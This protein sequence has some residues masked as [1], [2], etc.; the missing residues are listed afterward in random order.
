MRKNF[1][2]IGSFDGVHLGHRHLFDTLKICAK[3]NNMKP[4][5]I[6]FKVPPKVVLE[7]SHGVLTTQDEKMALLKKTGIRNIEFVDF[8][9]IRN[10]TKEK[11]FEVLL[12][13]YNMGAI[14]CG[15]DFAFGK[16]RGGKSA[17]LKK[18]CKENGVIFECADFLEN[19]GVKIS[20]SLIRKALK[21]GDIEAVNGMMGSAY[22]VGG[23]IVKGRQMG[24][25]IGFPTANI[26]FNP[27]KILPRGVYAVKAKLG[28]KE[29][30]GVCNIGCRPTVE[31][32][33]LPSC[34]VHILNFDKDI[35]GMQMTA[36]FVAKIRSE[37]K[38]STL[39]ELTRQINKDSI[40]AYK[41]LKHSVE[42]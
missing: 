27:L 34:E 33:G 42:F 28:R 19:G 17:Y 18:A 13:K 25:K 40:L 16:D 30:M 29:Y 12:K 24:R 5:L 14:L 9:K 23:K 4:L 32:G 8:K 6:V 3:Q 35:Y 15:S 41:L 20:S 38:F 22:E 11:F 26:A 39:G 31:E 10:L 37:K 36:E 21:S 1:I 7:P 2:T